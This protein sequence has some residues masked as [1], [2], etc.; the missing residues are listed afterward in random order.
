MVGT[1]VKV[2][3][4]PEQIEL[5]GE[6][7]ATAGMTPVTTTRSNTAIESHPVKILVRVTV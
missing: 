7:I 4:P 1:A 3:L 6:V 2:M 5:V